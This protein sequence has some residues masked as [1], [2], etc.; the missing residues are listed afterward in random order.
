[1]K[2]TENHILEMSHHK[3]IHSSEFWV[4]IFKLI[5]F[6]PLQVGK[7]P[8]YQQL[9]RL[10][11]NSQKNLFLCL[12]LRNERFWATVQL[13]SAVNLPYLWATLSVPLTAPFWASTKVMIHNS[14]IFWVCEGT[15]SPNSLFV[16][17]NM[18]PFMDQNLLNI[19][20]Q[21]SY[22]RPDLENDHNQN[23]SGGG[24]VKFPESNETIFE[25]EICTIKYNQVK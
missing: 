3:G 25:S 2:T 12:A 24:H 9:C 1:M 20:Y 21:T 10:Y 16:L 7:S 17:H 22:K 19:V 5:R 23:N 11:D 13:H 4:A 15:Y 14:P 18:L 6:P 8:G